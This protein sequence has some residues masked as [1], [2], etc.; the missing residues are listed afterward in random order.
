MSHW[1]G[2]IFVAIELRLQSL[3]YDRCE[4]QYQPLISTIPEGLV[5]QVFEE[6]VPREFVVVLVCC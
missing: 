6:R 4:F 3:R 2:A 1:F 5:D